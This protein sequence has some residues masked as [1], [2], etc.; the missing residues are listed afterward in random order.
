MT[1]KLLHH[2]FETRSRIELRTAGLRNYAQDPSTGVWCCAFAVNEKPVQLWVPSDPVPPEFTAAASD[3]KWILCAH[4]AEFERM[5]TLHVLAPQYGWPIAPLERWYCT[6]AAARTVGLPG[7]LEDLA[8]LLELTNQKDKA[9]EAVMKRLSRPDPKTGQ[10]TEDPDLIQK[11]YAY[12]R[13]DV[14]VERELHHRLPPL[15]DADR[16]LW[17]TDA[18]TNDRGVAFDR[19]L[20]AAG[21]RI[22]QQAKHKIETELGT[23]TSG[24]VETVGQHAKLESW[25]AAQEDTP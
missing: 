18:R 2:D 16:T 20:A 14:R 15:A 4:N 10:W 7:K 17:H 21:R 8:R 19:E 12:C 5:I 6:M 24:R 9:G 22:A 1:E 11:L 3:P 13:Q 25:I 23:I